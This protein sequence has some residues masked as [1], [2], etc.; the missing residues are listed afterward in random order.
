MYGPFSAVGRRP[1]TPETT[2]YNCPTTPFSAVRPTLPTPETA[3]YN[4]YNTPYNVEKVAISGIP[5]KPAIS[6]F[7]IDGIRRNVL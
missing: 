6:D 3:P 2:P 1:K 4:S 5:K 7:F